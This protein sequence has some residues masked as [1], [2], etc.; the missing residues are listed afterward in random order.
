MEAERLSGEPPAP[1]TSHLAPLAA[2]PVPGSKVRIR[3]LG[4]EGEVESVKGD[5]VAVRVRGRR[6]RV[7]LADLAA[8]GT[9]RPAASGER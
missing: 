8:A 5:D 9:A 4:L 7:R 2:P 3:S 1:R 6:V